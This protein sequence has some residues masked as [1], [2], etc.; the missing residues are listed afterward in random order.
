ME[1]ARQLDIFSDNGIEQGQPRQLELPLEQSAPPPSPGAQLELFPDKKF[2][3]R[4]SKE[5]VMDVDALQRWK[6]QILEYQQQT[7]VTPPTEQ[8]A[9][10]DLAPSHCERERID[11]LQLQMQSMAFYRMPADYPGEA[12]LYFVIDSA[13]GLIL[14]VGET[15]RSNKRWKGV[16]DCKEYIASYQDLHYK[17]KLKTAVNIAFWWETPQRREWRQELEQYLIL[18]W[19]APFNKENWARWGQ[20][21]GKIV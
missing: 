11:P 1:K 12:C 17:Y 2:R 15:C 21:F 10:F 16:H 4:R 14:Y 7:R 6:N 8:T 5:L 13:P 3:A 19:K 20:P 18:K 9:L